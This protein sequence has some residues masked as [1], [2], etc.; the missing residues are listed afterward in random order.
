MTYL[1]S[2]GWLPTLTET[3]DDLVMQRKDHNGHRRLRNLGSG[4]RGAHGWAMSCPSSRVLGRLYR[5]WESSSGRQ[6][7]RTAW[8]S[9]ASDPGIHPLTPAAAS[10]R[11]RHFAPCPCPLI[12]SSS[13]LFPSLW[14]AV[15]CRFPLHVYLALAGSGREPVVRGEGLQTQITSTYTYP[16]C[17]IC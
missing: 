17:S 3:G 2:P 13:C 16:T 12:S 7:R 8:L 1:P 15:A 11:P 4:G 14:P 10:P 6:G 9:S 5:S